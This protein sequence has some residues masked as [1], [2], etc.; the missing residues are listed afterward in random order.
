MR[1]LVP[2]FLA[3][4]AIGCGS[5]RVYLNR[6]V[7]TAVVL[8]PL[9]ESPDTQAGW[10]M[11]P[12]VEDRVASRGYRI[13]PHAEVQKFYEDKKY[14]G[15]P[16]QISEF[17]TEELAKI[18]NVDAVVWSKVVSWDKKT[19]GIYNSIEVKLEAELHD[20]NREILWKGEGQDGYSSAPSSKSIFSSF[21]GTAVADPE[22]YAPGAAMNC[23]GSLPWAGWDPKAPREPAPVPVK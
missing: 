6:D 17:S 14:T 20:R 21:V 10:K 18:F 22:K 23:F 19:L 11:W 4:F 8:A 13:V 5:S 7:A 3:V 1:F 9:N 12:Y 15:D 16:G 2:A